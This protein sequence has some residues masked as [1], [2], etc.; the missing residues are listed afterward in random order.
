MI[1]L[2]SLLF[3]VSLALN[4]TPFQDVISTTNQ[5]CCAT[6]TH[7][8]KCPGN[9]GCYS[10]ETKNQCSGG[11]CPPVDT[12]KVCPGLPDPVES[13]EKLWHWAQRDD[14]PWHHCKQAPK[15]NKSD[16]WNCLK[17]GWFSKTNDNHGTMGIKTQF[18][19]ADAICKE[20]GYIEGADPE[21]WGYN[22]WKKCTH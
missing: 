15:W 8:F 10:E 22:Q 2:L 16:P 11:V 6:C 9:G 12:S 13:C 21:K 19:D 20:Q 1:Y 4:C 5:N 7:P 3:T 17:E 18:V 14:Q